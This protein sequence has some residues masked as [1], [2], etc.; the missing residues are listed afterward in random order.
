MAG[1]KVMEK[2]GHDVCLCM[3]YLVY[4]IYNVLYNADLAFSI[5]LNVQI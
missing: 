3:S 2:P 4:Y 5:H 1:L